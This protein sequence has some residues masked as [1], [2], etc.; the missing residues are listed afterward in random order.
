MKLLIL[1]FITSVGG[2]QA[3]YRNIL[4]YL[5]KE[6]DVYFLDPYNHDYNNELKKIHA[7]NVINKPINSKSNLGWHGNIINR[8][9][10]LARNGVTYLNYL[11]KLIKFIKHK[12]I[13]LLYVSGKKEL[14]FAFL[15]SKIY[16]LPY[17]YHSHGFS[18]Y[19]DISYLFR[20][21]INNAT[22][23][24]AVSKN[25]RTDLIK[26]RVKKDK[27]VVVNNGLNIETAKKETKD[28]KL[29]CSNG[30]DFNLILIA[31][32]QPLKGIHILIQA[33]NMLLE[34]GCEVTLTIIGD[35]PNDQSKDYKEE[36]R[37]LA[38]EVN[39]EKF[40]FKGFQKNVYPYINKADV[41]VLPSF[42]E[43][44]GMVLLE[45]M[46]LSKPLIGSNVGGI[47]EIIKDGENGFL[48][49][50][51]KVEELAKSINILYQDR[52]LCQQLGKNG[53][54]HLTKYYTSKTQAKKILDYIDRAKNERK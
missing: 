17:V 30:S 54:Q 18:S 6:H 4:P 51:G 45:G 46:Y 49:E 8:I 14:L 50:P 7:L 33:V 11:T 3:V 15:I 36:L 47:P 10:I 53:K 34:K 19:K 48:F 25:V 42:A 20:L 5:T 13:E 43:S 37:M 52:G 39:K 40:K 16:G 21:F 2:V 12:E 24:L 44:F 31:T 32:I 26:A 41:L 1:E 22:Y 9:F 23:I 28:I 38:Q 29:N 27:V 35:I